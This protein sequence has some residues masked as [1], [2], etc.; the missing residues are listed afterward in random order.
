MLAIGRCRSSKGFWLRNAA[1]ILRLAAEFQG[2]AR[3]LHC[4]ACSRFAS[5][6]ASTSPAVESVIR[7]RLREGR[8]SIVAMLTQEASV[9]VSGSSASRYGLPWRD[10]TRPQRRTTSLCSGSTLPGML[11]P[12][13][14]PP[15]RPPCNPR[16]TPW[17]S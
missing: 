5:W 9:T 15:P 2:F 1:L 6:T 12:T 7:N 11:L 4:L 3:D 17:F 8:A 13:A 16:A 14:T 10:G